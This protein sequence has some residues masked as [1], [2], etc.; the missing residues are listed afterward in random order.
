MAEDLIRKLKRNDTG[1]PVRVQVESEESG[2][3]H[4][5]TGAFAVFTMTDRDGVIKVNRQPAVVEA[6][7][8]GFMR[9]EWQAG[10]TDTEG[11][12][13][14]EFEVDFGSGV[15]ET[16]PGEQ[17]NIRIIIAPDLDAT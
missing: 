8:D 4:D 2:V 6:G 9:Y 15:K 7:T 12:Y 11:V 10:D 1:P 14:A 17:H 5:L 3:G 13:D 16:Y